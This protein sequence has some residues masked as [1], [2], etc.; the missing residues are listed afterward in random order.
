MW[1]WLGSGLLTSTGRMTEQH[2]ATVNMVV[3]LY[4]TT[5]VKVCQ[6]YF[7]TV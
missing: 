2:S 6:Q 1:P 7:V 3:E 5:G 4:C